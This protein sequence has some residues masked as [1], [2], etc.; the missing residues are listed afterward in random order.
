MC[1]VSSAHTNQV[2]LGGI[3]WSSPKCWLEILNPKSHKHH[4]ALEITKSSPATQFHVRFLPAL[5]PARTKPFFGFRRQCP[6]LKF[7]KKLLVYIYIG[8]NLPIWFNK[9]TLAPLK[10]ANPKNKPLNK[11]NNREVT[12]FILIYQFYQNKKAQP[13]KFFETKLF[14]EFKFS[15]LPSNSQQEERKKKKKKKKKNP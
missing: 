5:A 14:S 15:I 3:S 2:Y 6:P 1:I 4:K 8:N 7:G 13:L 10:I 9:I 11:I 12:K